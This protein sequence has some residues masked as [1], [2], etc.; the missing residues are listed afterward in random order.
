MEKERK[1]GEWKEIMTKEL[2]GDLKNSSDIYM[3]EYI[4]LKADEVNELR[5]QLETSSSKYLVVKNSIA[6]IALE[7][8]GLG[9]LAKFVNGNTGMVLSGDNPILTARIISKFSKDHE[10]LKIK[11]GLLDGDIIDMARIKFLASL[12]GREELI[13]RIAYGMKSPISG[14]VFLLGNMLKSLVY[15]M[16]AIKD[17]KGG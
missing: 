10:A 8:A 3:S 9:D 15:V 16:Q 1:I 4:G 7:S 2:A 6:R 11:G 17:K 5:R 14:F 13:A 12:P